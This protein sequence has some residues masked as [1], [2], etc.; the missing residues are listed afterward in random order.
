MVEVIPV[1]MM[2]SFVA[3]LGILFLLIW[4]LWKGGRLRKHLKDRI[5]VEIWRKTGTVDEDFYDKSVQEIKVGNN[6]TDEDAMT[7]TLREDACYN[8][9]YPKKTWFPWMQ[10]TV[11]KIAFIEGNPEPLTKRRKEVVA[12]AKLIRNLRE[13]AFTQFAVA[14]SQHIRELSE[15]LEKTVKPST[16]YFILIGIGLLSAV[17][18][19]FGFQAYN[20]L[21]QIAA[22]LG[23]GG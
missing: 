21:N 15:M 23:I 22:G 18:A 1:W 7:Y 6:P 3:L 2:N 5:L 13:E 9:L 16:L 14:T 19:I 8:S 17:G 4:S 11:K 10:V 12:S 20:A